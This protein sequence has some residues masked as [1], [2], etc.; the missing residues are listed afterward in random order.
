MCFS[1]LFTVSG[2]E[3]TSATM[4]LTGSERYFNNPF[5]EDS[6]AGASKVKIFF[7]YFCSSGCTRGGGEGWWSEHSSILIRSKLLHH[8]TGV[9]T[10][11]I[12]QSNEGL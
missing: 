5:L 2:S 11:T 4:F 6:G 9:I 7:S 3:H 12:Y 10:I 8:I 1:R